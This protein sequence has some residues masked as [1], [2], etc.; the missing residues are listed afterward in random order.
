MTEKERFG[1]RVLCIY[2]G[3]LVIIGAVYAI[4]SRKAVCTVDKVKVSVNTTKG[5]RQT[6]LDGESL[7][8]MKN[9]VR[10]FNAEL[11]ARTLKE[12]SDG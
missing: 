9:R 6:R 2:V 11:D 10:Y 12:P 7:E 8:K 3:L 5:L 1:Y 4:L